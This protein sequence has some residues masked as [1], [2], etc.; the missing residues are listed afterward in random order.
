[1]LNPWISPPAGDLLNDLGEG[2]T[3]WRVTDQVR[4]NSTPL[5]LS[6]LSREI[7]VGDLKSSSGGSGRPWAIGD[8]V[9]LA[10]SFSTQPDSLELIGGVLPPG[11]V[12]NATTFKIQGVIGIFPKTAFNY[13]VVFRATIDDEIFD[14]TFFWIMD[15]SDLEQQWVSPLLQDLGAV[16][17]GSNVIIPLDLVNP[18]GDPL[19][20]KA[21]GAASPI[22]GQEAF[23]GLPRGLEIDSFGRI[24]GSPL[25]T[26]NPP[27]VYYFR[28]YVRD[29]DDLGDLPRGQGLPSLTSEKL[30][31]ITLNQAI[32][33]DSR[34]S[35]TVRWITPAGS[36]G[37]TY[38]TYPSHFGVEAVPQ[39]ETTGSSSEIQ[40][41]RYSLA[42]G[43]KPLPE[44]L[45]L[46]P[47]SGLIIGRA[48]YVINTRVFEFTVDARV[49]L[50]NRTTG[51]VVVSS[52]GSQRT[53]SIS[54]RNLFSTNA[55]SNI[56]VTVPPD[57]RRKIISWTH[58]VRPE[59]RR[60][61]GTNT[62]P[63]TLTLFGPTNVFRLADPLWGRVKDLKIRL[64]SGLNFLG[65][66]TVVAAEPW[67]VGDRVDQGGV[68][69][70]IR[71]GDILPDVDGVSRPIKVADLRT[72]GSV[73]SGS[74][75]DFLD[76]LSDYHHPTTLRV[77][78]VAWARGLSPEG[79][80]VY[81][82]IYLGVTDPKEGAGGFDSLGRETRELRPH[83]PATPVQRLNIQSGQVNYYPNSIRNFRLD[84]IQRE[85]R[86]AG[87]LPGY[88]FSGSEGLPFWQ[89]HEQVRGRPAT[90]LGY[91]AAIE[92]A[93][94]RP[95]TAAGV[96]RALELAGI[97]NDLQGMTIEVDRYLVITNGFTA[98]DFDGP[99]VQPISPLLP[100]NLEVVPLPDTNPTP[101]ITTFDGPDSSLSPTISPT[102]FDTILIEEGKYYKFTPG[103]Q[104]G[105]Q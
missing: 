46:D 32:A 90:R 10:L 39:F 37:S 91:Q 4:I 44:G 62:G 60:I 41:I 78:R 76:R 19:E 21:I 69:E 20:F 88:G 100:P 2:S 51:Q 77:G 45:L 92:I 82:V 23:Q 63:N 65:S 38:E 29:P 47:G 71:V 25:V 95:G 31:R 11:V 49:V 84:L 36:L 67:R 85:N 80:H 54:V 5:D 9:N 58:S 73:G 13:P 24:V 43:S 105:N 34:L 50:T 86:L 83:S 72:R 42:P 26:D 53:F 64:I 52:I 1:M 48:P 56:T 96:V 98:L 81:D 18:D 94:L 70:N 66:E 27:G 79:V 87:S 104:V 3:P 33:Q 28:V 17:R 89:F 93:Y 61:V 57:I 14:R 16:D 55:V 6:G 68:V 30:Y 74:G 102:T 101:E 103:D 97:N 15:T 22:A 7:R 59:L 12:F 40:S 99:T 35:D 75:S 8:I